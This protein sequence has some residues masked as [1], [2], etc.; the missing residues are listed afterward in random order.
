M[1]ATYVHL[2]PCLYWASNDTKFIRLAMI[3][4]AS[5]RA[6]YSGSALLKGREVEVIEMYKKYVRYVLIFGLDIS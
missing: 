5:I 3:F 1:M 2:R 4:Q 6:D